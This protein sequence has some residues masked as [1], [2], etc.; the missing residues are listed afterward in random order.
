MMHTA[1]FQ[2]TLVRYSLLVF[3]AL[4]CAAA[5]A[6]GTVWILAATALVSVACLIHVFKVSAMELLVVTVPVSFYAGAG[7]LTMNV[8]VSDFFVVIIAVQLLGDREVRNTVSRLATPLAT[9][10]VATCL[11]V[12]ICV[13]TIWTRSVLG[14]GTNRIDFITN[15][16]KLV[17]VMAVFAVTLIAFSRLSRERMR[18]LLSVWA[19]TAAAVGALGTAGSILYP[20][21]IDIGMSYD[22]RATATFEDPNAFASYLILSIPLCCLA[23]WLSGRHLFGWQLLPILAGVYTSYSRGAI[24]ALVV[25][26]AGLAILSL[27]DPKLLSLRMFSIVIAVGAVWLL[28]SG[29]LDALFEDVRGAGFE[30]DGRFALWSAAWELWKSSPI[31][32]IGMGQFV[33]SAAAF[34]DRASVGVIAHNTYLS[35]LAETG[36]IGFVLFMLIPCQAI[37]ALI[38]DKGTGARLLLGSLLGVLTTGASLNLQNSRSLWVLLALSLAWVAINHGDKRSESQTAGPFRRAVTR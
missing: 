12:V 38:R 31:F 13:G 4:L 3:V 28:L 14:F 2:R 18:R 16:F 35:M 25:M 19:T 29:A 30:S 27:G 32:G 7:P 37:G 36:L 33:E 10:I 21:G 6:G 20:M 23:R 24:V 17:I 26:V 34:I 11:L 9:A 15:T 22:F 5:A 1:E 8:T